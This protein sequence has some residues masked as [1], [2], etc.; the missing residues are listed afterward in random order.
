MAKAH[1]FGI[2]LCMVHWLWKPQNIRNGHQTIQL[3]ITLASIACELCITA[4]HTA[5]SPLWTEENTLSTNR[6]LLC[7]IVYYWIINLWGK[8]IVRL[9]IVGLSIWR[10]SSHPKQ[11]Y[12]WVRNMI[13]NCWRRWTP[14]PKVKRNFV[15]KNPIRLRPP[16]W[17]SQVCG[18]GFQHSWICSLA[19]FDL[20]WQWNND[21]WGLLMKA[22]EILQRRKTSD[23]KQGV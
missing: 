7:W 20:N 5:I 23:T 16:I 15:P 18:I 2:G 12:S 9:W 3:W 14:I 22:K 1:G 13:I 11:N 17:R 10:M 19:R 8:R 6:L 4:D 21:S